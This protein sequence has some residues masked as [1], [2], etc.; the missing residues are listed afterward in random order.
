MP[1]QLIFPFTLQ[2]IQFSCLGIV[3]HNHHMSPFCD[4]P[5]F[6]SF[7]RLHSFDVQVQVCHKSESVLVPVILVYCGYVYG[8]TWT[9]TEIIYLYG[10]HWAL[11]LDHQNR[12][13]EAQSRIVQLERAEA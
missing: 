10:V 9:L 8:V 11:V 4:S 5:S 3:L 6:L 13:L 2:F 7:S 1:R 12:F